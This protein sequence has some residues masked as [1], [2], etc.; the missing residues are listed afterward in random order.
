M[1]RYRI[2]WNASSNISFEGATDWWDWDDEGATGDD[3]EDAL[4][5]GCGLLSQGLGIALEASG[6]DWWVESREA[7]QETEAE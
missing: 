2:C 3:V 1:I 6:F 5:S 4:T 7:A